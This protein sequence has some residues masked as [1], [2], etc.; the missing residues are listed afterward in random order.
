VDR[1]SGARPEEHTG[2]RCIR[3]AMGEVDPTATKDLPL[4]SIIIIGYPGCVKTGIVEMQLEVL[5]KLRER[6]IHYLPPTRTDTPLTAP[7]VTQPELQ[8]Q[9]QQQHQKEQKMIKTLYP[10]I[11]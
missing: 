5:L 7:H 3:K 6:C 1:P 10:E 9:Q 4:Q 11:I 8:S 2:E